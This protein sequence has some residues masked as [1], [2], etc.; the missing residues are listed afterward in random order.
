MENWDGDL[1]KAL[2]EIAINSK[3]RTLKCEMNALELDYSLFMI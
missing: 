2:A 1:E 3:E